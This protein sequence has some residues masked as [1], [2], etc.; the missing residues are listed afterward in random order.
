MPNGWQFCSHSRWFFSGI[1]WQRFPWMHHSSWLQAFFDKRLCCRLVSGYWDLG[2]WGWEGQW[3]PLISSKAILCLRAKDSHVPWLISWVPRPGNRLPFP[4]LARVTPAPKFWPITCESSISRVCAF[5]PREWLSVYKQTCARKFVQF[6][7]KGGRIGF[8]RRRSPLWGCVWGCRWSTP[9]LLCDSFVWP[10]LSPYFFSYLGLVQSPSHLRT[11][12]S[13]T[14]L[15]S[16]QAFVK[17]AGN[18]D[19]VRA[20]EQRA[21]RAE[22]YLGD[23]N[24]R[25][26][27]R[28]G[29]CRLCFDAAHPWDHI[30]IS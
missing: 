11:L 7:C 14:H 15:L 17:R 19:S 30:L 12:M 28:G 20:C 21:K 3:R 13:V 27:L 4:V 25:R 5:L 18:S 8:M 22:P 1:S 29:T 24:R 9:V 16:P 2:W 23:K 6:C 26:S 10:S